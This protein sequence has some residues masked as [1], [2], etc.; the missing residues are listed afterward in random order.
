MIY[1]KRDSFWGGF[2]LVLSDTIASFVSG[3]FSIIRL[4]GMFIVGA[5]L[6]A[7]EIPHYFAWLER[8]TRRRLDGMKRKLTKTVAV[9]LFFNPL[10]IFRHFV[11]IYLLL[12]KTDLIN[13]DL[14]HTAIL[15]FAFN[16]PFS[17]IG[18]YIIQNK[19]SLKW[20]FVFSSVFSAMIT[21]YYSLSPMIFG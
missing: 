15:S 9:A 12:G 7:V 2:L 20:R 8:F 10:W 5:A 4:V 21:L 3:D 11:F 6:Y 17:L 16:L 13:G 18:N 14:F 1:T 19:I